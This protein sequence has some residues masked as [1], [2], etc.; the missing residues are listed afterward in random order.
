MEYFV[1]FFHT[2]QDDKATKV[3]EVTESESESNWENF[4]EK[5]D[6]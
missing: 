6:E 1:L 2:K 4:I 3:Q 5:R